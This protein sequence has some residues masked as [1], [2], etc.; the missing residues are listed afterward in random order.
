MF[1]LRTLLIAVTLAGAAVIASTPAAVSDRIFWSPSLGRTMPYRVIL[2]DQ[3]ASATARYP[4]LFLLHGYGGGFSDW[5]AHT[6][7]ADYVAGRPLI[8][9][10]PEGA[11]SWFV[12][13]ETGDAWETY[14]TS[15]LITEV[16]SRFRT[17]A[18][19][20]G[21]MIAGLSMGG[22]AAVKAGL[23]HPDLY[24]LV[25]SFSGA[26]DITRP[27]DV[28]KGESKPDVMAVF[29]P[30]GSAVRKA[31]D[32]FALAS[33][34]KVQ[35]LPYF[36]LACGTSDPWLEPNREMAR[37]LKARGIASE[38]HEQAGGHDWTFWDAAVKSFLNDP[39]VPRG[40]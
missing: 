25:G 22:Y 31:N 10:M 39:H 19:R 30:I 16:D 1:R 29:G 8:V 9:V 2:P 33:T 12:N 6:K 24:A 21:R 36:F 32:V 34:A 20:D 28:F 38:Y 13:S 11:N 40:K 18:T 4:V 35:G 26:F 23:K 15:D 27:G 5:T 7:V 14:L 37:T 17:T 3:Y